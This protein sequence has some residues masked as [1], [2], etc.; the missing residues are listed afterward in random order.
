VILTSVSSKHIYEI[1]TTPFRILSQAAREID[2]IAD[3][4]STLPHADKARSAK[5]I[6]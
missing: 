1:A 4:S 3:I 2:A 6:K 5:R